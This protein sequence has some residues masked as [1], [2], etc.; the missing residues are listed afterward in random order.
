MFLS[1]ERL[2]VPPLFGAFWG[3][4]IGWWL[5][6]FRGI[7]EYLDTIAVFDA[8]RKEAEYLVWF[9]FHN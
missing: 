3:M 7:A 4:I 5:A 9:V 6:V 8:V 1:V 2:F